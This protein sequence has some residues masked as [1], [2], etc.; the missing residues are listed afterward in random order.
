MR[1]VRWHGQWGG[2]DPFAGMTP[3][4]APEPGPW[5]ILTRATIRPAKLSAF[6]GAV[7]SAATHLSEQPE[8]LNSVG[9][10]EAPLLYQATVSLWRTLPS[11]Q[12]FAYSHGIH[13]N[14][15][16]RTRQE[17]WY[18]EELFAR[19]CPVASFRT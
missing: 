1:P 8:L 6:L 19:L 3:V 13:K 18:R 4:A 14:I 16:Q 17:R 9:V 10:G 7:P 15:V 5:I 2:R 11:I 12:G